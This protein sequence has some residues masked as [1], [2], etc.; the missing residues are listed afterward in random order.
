MKSGYKIL[1]LSNLKEQTES[2]LIS[3]I[4]MAKMIGGSIELFYVKQPNEVVEDANQL[5]AMRSINDQFNKTHQEISALIAKM[6]KAYDTAIDFSFSF[7]NA[8]AEISKRLSELQ[9]DLV[10]LGKKKRAPLQLLGDS[11]T[12][13]VIKTFQGPVLITS[14][15]QPIQPN[16]S[17]RLGLFNCF[18][19]ELNVAFEAS[20]MEHASPHIKSFKLL[21]DAKGY[22]SKSSF[23]ARKMIE[24]VF[25]N[26]QSSIQ[27]LSN[28]I[29][30][31]EIDLLFMDRDEKLLKTMTKAGLIHDATISMLIAQQ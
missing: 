16:K 29:N 20:I 21:K 9:P 6:H 26:N 12:Q 5:S 24:F 7:G 17:V 25:K 30:K 18:E 10:V 14:R 3:T 2:T 13:H 15:A 4:A 22:Q 31:S 8:K 11:I 19:D 28:Y 1:L 27:N 23:G